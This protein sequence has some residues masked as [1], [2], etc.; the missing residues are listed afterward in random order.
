MICNAEWASPSF[1]VLRIAFPSTAITSPLSPICSRMISM[2]VCATCFPSIMRKTLLTVGF[3][4]I[5]CIPKFCAKKSALFWIYTMTALN[6]SNPHK[7]AHMSMT[8]ISC[9]RCYEHDQNIL[10]PVLHVTLMPLVR[11]LVEIFL[12]LG[13][14]RFPFFLRIPYKLSLCKLKFMKRP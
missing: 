5:S 1:D 4:G 11:Y 14:L 9:N 2:M 7:T 13:I 6:S 10:Q 12:H 8:R 3:D